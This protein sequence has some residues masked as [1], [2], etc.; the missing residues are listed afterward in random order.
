MKKVAIFTDGSCLGNPGPGGWA[1]ILTLAGTEHRREICGGYRLTTNNRMEIMAAIQ[2]LAALREPCGVEMFT[3][4]QY[5]CDAVNKGWLKTWQ[6][7]LWLKANKKPVLNVD[8]WLKLLE[9]MA[10]HSL[11]IRWLAGHAGHA[12][13]ERCDEL[14][15]NCASGANLPP[16]GEFEKQARQSKSPGLSGTG[17]SSLMFP[18]TPTL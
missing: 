1:A 8:L 5:L 17:P 11:S 7:N 4:S 10:R 18:E 16:D 3:D 15:R 9:Q 13:N 14:A 12:E 6:K 2:G